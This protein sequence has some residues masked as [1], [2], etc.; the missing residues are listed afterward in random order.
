M[1]N[2]IL[3]KF[4][5]LQSSL[6]ILLLVLLSILVLE[7]TI[8]TGNN[9]IPKSPTEAQ[10]TQSNIFT[11]N[12]NWIKTKQSDQDPVVKISSP[13]RITVSPVCESHISLLLTDFPSEKTP[14]YQKHLLYTLQTSS[15]L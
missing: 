12:P 1:K 13:N 5:K 10:I 11:F 14:V 9:P 6:S 8:Q 3:N 2:G 15:D 4:S 7:T